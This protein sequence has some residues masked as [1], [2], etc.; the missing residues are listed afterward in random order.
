[1]G[2]RASA[3]F[4]LQT[5]IFPLIDGIAK[6]ENLSLREEVVKMI[7]EG[8]TIGAYAQRPEYRRRLDE[9]IGSPTACFVLDRLKNHIEK[10]EKEIRASVPW[11]IERIKETR[12]EICVEIT[13]RPGGERWLGDTFVDIATI[14]RGYTQPRP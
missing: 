1:M 2:K 4:Y 6:K 7:E 14:C 13:T 3:R 10:P 5:M 9:T 11:W 8:V 12:P